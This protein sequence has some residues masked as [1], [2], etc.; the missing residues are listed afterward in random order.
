[1]C[2]LFATEASGKGLQ[3]T[4]QAGRSILVPLSLSCP[5]GKE[6]HVSR[7][8]IGLSGWRYAGWR[9]VFYPPGAGPG[10]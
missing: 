5:I 1:M 8:H 2:R 9:G 10:A 3:A 7:I 4:L 6:D